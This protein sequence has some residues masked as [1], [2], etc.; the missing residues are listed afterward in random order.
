MTSSFWRKLEELVEK[1]E[2][3]LDRPKGSVHPRRPEIIY[4]LDYGYLAETS[5]GD[6][7][8]VDVWRGSLEEAHLDA[9]VCTADP[10]K[11]DAEIKVLLGCSPAEQR[12]IYEFH[13]THGMG[14]LLVERP[15]KNSE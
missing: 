8:E 15:E 13:E 9:V 6:G 12:L 2:V 10:H 4:P 14:A 5:G 1:S 7:D 3:V 11:R